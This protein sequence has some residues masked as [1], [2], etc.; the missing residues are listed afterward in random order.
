MWAVGFLCFFVFFNLPSSTYTHAFGHTL[1]KRGQDLEV[2][3]KQLVPASGK[4]HRPK[5]EMPS[6]AR[7]VLPTQDYCPVAD[8]TC[9]L[10][11]RGGFGSLPVRTWVSS[12]PGVTQNVLILI[13]FSYFNT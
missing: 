7:P 6:A 2:E 4:S 5:E 8:N 3:A 13:E 11:G 1:T 9:G 12:I 10:V